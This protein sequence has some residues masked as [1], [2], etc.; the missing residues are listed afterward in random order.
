MPTKVLAPGLVE[1]I[2]AVN[3]FYFV[4]QVVKIGAK[5]P[6]AHPSV[7]ALPNDVKAAIVADKATGSSALSLAKKYKVGY[8]QVLG[9]LSRWDREHTLE[10]KPGSGRPRKTTPAQDRK[11]L[12]DVKRCAKMTGED[13][14]KLGALENISEK[15]VRRRITVCTTTVSRDSVRVHC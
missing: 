14:R 4:R 12:L 1:T 10:R 13:I 6:N 5:P 15:T 7:K 2:S 3:C 8:K 9:L 11:I